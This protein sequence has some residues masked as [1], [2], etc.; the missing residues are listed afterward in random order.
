M[1]SVVPTLSARELDQ[2]VED[3]ESWYETKIWAGED[4]QPEELARLHLNAFWKR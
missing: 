1:A 4:L 2:T 3:E